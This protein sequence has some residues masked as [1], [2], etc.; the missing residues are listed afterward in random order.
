MLG[1]FLQAMVGAMLWLLANAVYYDLRRKGERNFTRFAAFW[2]GTPT[3]WITLFA[4]RP[5]SR[6]TFETTDDESLLFEE[7]RR[8]REIRAGPG[9]PALAADGA[10]SPGGD[11]AGAGEEEGPSRGD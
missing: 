11:E 6:P 7:V 1:S 10:E 3:T 8:D 9:T 4:V 5:L 2:V